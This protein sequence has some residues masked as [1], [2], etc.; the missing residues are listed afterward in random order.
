[1][2]KYILITS[3]TKG[4]GLAVAKKMASENFSLILTYG[5]DSETA[6]KVQE[7]LRNEFNIAV[8]IIQA[9]ARESKSID[10]IE[11]FI[12][13]QKITLS[14]IVFNTGITAREP[15]EKITENEWLNVFYANLHQPT[16]LLQRLL[17][18]IEKGG[19]ILFTGSLMAIYPHSLSVPYAVSK[20]GV[21][22]LVQNLVKVLSPY[23]IRING[24]APGY[25]N[26]D[27]QKKKS[28]EVQTKIKERIALNRFGEPEELADIF[29]L[30]LQNKYMNGEIITVSGGYSFI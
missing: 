3:G 24:I 29:N 28:E 30:A 13:E 26:T 19:S 4:I 23:Q 1:M 25:T 6:E 8:A 22:S 5:S 12:T 2:K 16:F 9:D 15:F 14:H 17:K 27:W 21:H 11:K 10:T 18:N 20:A 7:D